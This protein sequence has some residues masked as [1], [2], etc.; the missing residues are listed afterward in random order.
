MQEVQSLDISITSS[1]LRPKGGGGRARTES[2]AERWDL[3]RSQ[4]NT[5]SNFTPSHISN[6]PTISI[7][8]TAA[9]SPPSVIPVP[10]SEREPAPRRSQSLNIQRVGEEFNIFRASP[11]RKP[12]PDLEKLLIHVSL[13]DQSHKVICITEDFFVQDII[14]LF[15]GKLGLAQTEYFSLC[16]QT[17]DGY[18]RWLDPTKLITDAGIRNLSKLIFKIKYFKQPKKLTDPKAVHLYYLQIQHSVVNGIYPCSEAMALR[19][20]ALQF[21]ITFGA[22]DKDQHVAGFLDHETLLGFI[23]L[24]HF[25]T[26]TDDQIKCNTIVEAKLRYLD[27]ANKIPTFG[28]TSFQVFDTSRE[29]SSART[30]RIICV[31]E[32]GL[33]IARK[34]KTGYDFFNYKDVIKCLSTPRGIKIQIPFSC[35]TQNT[36]ETM[37][38]DTSSNEQSNN[39]IELLTGYKYFIQFD[40]SLKGLCAPPTVDLHL[41]G[42]FSLFLPPKP[43]A[44]SDPLRSRAE[45]FKTIY[46]QLCT[47]YNTKPLMKFVDQVDEILDKEGSFRNLLIYTTI[48]LS[49]LNLRAADLSFIADALRDAFNT[50][51]EEGETLVENLDLHTIDLSN[52]PLLGS[53][54][55]EPFKILLQAAGTI[56]NINLKNI[57]ITNK[58]LGPFIS[59]FEKLDNIESLQ[60]GKNRIFEITENGFKQIFEGL[61]YNTTLKELNIS[62]NPIKYQQINKFL[63]W[64]ATSNTAINNL[65]IA[66]T[67]LNSSSGSEIQKILTSNGCQ[68]QQLDVSLNDLGSSGTKSVIKGV[69]ANNQITDLSLSGNKIEYSGIHTLCQSLETTSRLSKISLRYCN[70]SSKSLYRICKLLETNTTITSL[71]LSMNKISKSV[72]Q[73]LSQ[74][75]PSNKTLEEL[76]ITNCEMGNKEFSKLCV[77]LELNESLKR[78]YLDMNPFGK[79]GLTPLITVI[80]SNKVIEVITLRNITLNAK[81]TLDFLKKLNTN[82]TI[83]KINL[84]ENPIFAVEKLLPAIKNGIEENIKRLNRINIQ[85]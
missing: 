76:F 11:M 80:N 25:H 66:S 65:S 63:K 56:V 54:V 42:Q 43:R 64:F 28:V 51:I 84:S 68:L 6:T 57:G 39:I 29:S 30:A 85:I 22:H 34:D 9:P 17:T 61:Q 55:A 60:I 44:K 71:D 49:S 73:A 8:N 47:T 12:N 77:G 37:N 81:Y 62:G 83:Q 40:D 3:G 53:D 23:P 58:G 59:I 13:V 4:I 82:S 26:H 67:M 33:L 38:F 1:T 14:N 18:D 48:D 5:P 41:A 69:V 16:E 35:V 10:T 15:A 21:Y 72:C 70:L 19:L 36:S 20:S 27:L 75:L 79:K 7:T 78:I 32:N 50:P 52:N 46:L 31:A 24:A 74:C 2:I 45:L